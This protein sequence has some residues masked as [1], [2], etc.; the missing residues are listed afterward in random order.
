MVLFVVRVEHARRET[1]LPKRKG[2]RLSAQHGA[3]HMVDLPL[4]RSWRSQRLAIDVL[5]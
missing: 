3:E 4:G 5:R 1:R 2:S